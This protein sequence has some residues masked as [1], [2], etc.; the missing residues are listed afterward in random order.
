MSQ[1]QNQPFLQGACIP[2]VEKS[3]FKT[4]IWALT[5]LSFCL[6][7]L[8]LFYRAGLPVM[9]STSFCVSG[10]LAS[11]S[12]PHVHMLINIVWK[13]TKLAAFYQSALCA[14]LFLH[15]GHLPYW[16]QLLWSYSVLK[17]VCSYQRDEALFG[18][19]FLPLH[20][21]KHCRQ[22][23]ETVGGLSTCASPL[24]RLLNILK[25]YLS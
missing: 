8:I 14:D 4:K 2:F 20:V 15:S 7:Y 22:G 24:R 9:N 19:P 11:C 18:F 10:S 6:K 21:Y 16:F 12:F 13:L 5:P 3:H 1:S 23:S 17:L 25:M